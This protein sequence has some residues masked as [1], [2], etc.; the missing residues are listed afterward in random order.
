MEITKLPDK[1]LA[2]KLEI[3]DQESIKNGTFKELVSDM[4]KSMVES[5]G[6]G[7]AANQID[8]DLSIFVID[9]NLAK[10]SNVPDVFF[11]PEI[12]EYSKDSDEMEEGCLSIPGFYV[13]IERAKKIKIKFM[14]ETGKKQKI[15]A[16]GFL[17]RVLQHETDHLCGLTIKNRVKK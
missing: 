17:A 12:T 14:D 7:L 11:N 6:V 15:K 2:K 13:P 4:R 5:Q 1:I 16:R 10:E 8:Q 3:V 9:A